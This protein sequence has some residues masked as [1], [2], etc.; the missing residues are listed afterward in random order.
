[1]AD[2]FANNRARL[3]ALVGEGALVVVPAAGE[4]VRND[5][6]THE[7]R[8]DSSFFFLTGFDEPE[9][10]AVIAPG[11]PEAEF[12]LFVRPR[13]R[14]MEVWNGYRAGVEG[15]RSAF[16]ADAAHEVADFSKELRKLAI[17]RERLYYALGGSHDDTV[18][19]LL[20]TMRAH[21]QS[22]GVPV[23]L[24]VS[25]LGPVLADLRV[26]KTEEEQ[27]A[28]RAACGL[29]AEGHM[30]AMRVAQPGLHEY[31]VQA[32]ME[33]VFR[34]GGAARVG[35]PS[36]VASGRNAC[37]LHYVENRRRMEKGDL[38]LIDA[39]AEQ[40]YLSADIT[41]TFPVDGRY[42]GPQRAVYEVVLAAQRAALASCKPGA[43]IRD[44]HDAATRVLAEG[45]VELALVPRGLEDTLAM[46]H[47]KEYFMHG[48]SHWLGMDVHDAGTY[49][50]D[51]RHRVLEP[52]MAFTVEPGLYVGTE[53]V[54][55]EFA[56]LEYDADEWRERR[57]L[58]GLEAAKR[59]EEQ[60]REKA[61][62]V[63]H[64]VPEELHGIGVRIEDDVLVTQEGID[65]LTEAVPTEA[66]DVEEMVAEAPR[67]WRG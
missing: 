40:G 25:D 60:E 51:R 1:M 14:E 27:E 15:A 39:A 55:V 33:A 23:P 24:D 63:S 22:Y 56:L 43:T 47:Y 5:D 64:R 17:G 48:T 31:Q 8:Q 52:G 13:D 36:I 7:F 65:N 4:T 28:L 59:E 41:R 38:L 16:G 37:V 34:W 32:A 66:D 50:V 67:W 12:S 45:L 3:A 19:G 26:R 29:S 62:K 9:A 2:R 20:R 10:V 44:P 49:R 53:D 6:V 21:H 18:I 46:H 57:I 58:L 30:E 54:D 61:E 11:H 35:Y 42:T